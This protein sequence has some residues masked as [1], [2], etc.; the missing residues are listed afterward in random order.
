[1]VDG[2]ATIINNVI[3]NLAKGF[4]INNDLTTTPCYVIKGFGMFAH[5]STV[6]EAREALQEKM[7]ANMN[8]EQA[9]E[10]FMKTFALNKSY[11]A[12]EFY[13]WHNRLTGSCEM[14]RNQFVEE[15][16]IDLDKDELTVWEFIELTKNAYGWNIIG[17][18][19]E[20]L[21]ARR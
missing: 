1:M 8:T 6:Q 16:N 10:C 3:G 9:I 18:L 4:V 2:I 21:E 17:R 19:A 5:G 14:G 11:P 12:R 13:I 15:H 7:F 20:R